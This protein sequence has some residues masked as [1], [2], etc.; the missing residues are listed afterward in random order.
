MNEYE[1]QHD[2]LERL[3]CCHD[4]EAVATEISMVSGGH[5]ADICTV[6]GNQL[7]AYELKLT[8]CEHAIEQALNYILWGADKAYVVTPKKQMTKKALDR[9]CESGIGLLFYLPENKKQIHIGNTYLPD[10]IDFSYPFEQII[11]PTLKR[12]ADSDRYHDDLIAEIK[13]LHG[14]YLKIA[15]RCVKNP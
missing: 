8:Y 6:I 3:R 9:F 2:C 5:Y 11:E 12:P 1:M 15:S 4:F 10:R 14:E 13:H 7:I